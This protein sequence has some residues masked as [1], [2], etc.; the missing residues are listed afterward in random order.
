MQTD[1][2]GPKSLWWYADNAEVVVSLTS[3]IDREGGPLLIKL[4]RTPGRKD[5]E[6]MHLFSGAVDVEDY[7]RKAE[8]NA[9]KE[10]SQR[11]NVTDLAERVSQ[12]EAEVASLKAK[13]D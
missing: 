12:L 5:A 7:N 8:A 6:Y 11:I 9:P 2:Q 3:L 13:L 10:S 1:P 4:P